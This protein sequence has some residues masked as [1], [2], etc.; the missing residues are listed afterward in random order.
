MDK[1]TT[2]CEEVRHL[3]AWYPTSTLSEEEERRVREHVEACESCSELLRFA[4]DTQEK[5]ETTSS[6]HPEP[7][8]LVRFAEEPA[9]LT[10][11]ERSA[12]EGHVALCEEC[13]QEIAI[14]EAVDA[15]DPTAETAPLPSP[16]ARGPGL[17]GR[18]CRLWD[19]LTTTLLR[20][21]PAALY[22]ATATAAV[23]LLLLQPGGE[24]GRRP[25]PGEI[26]PLRGTT[27]GS[28][29]LL[30]DGSDRVRGVGDEGPVPTM[31]AGKAQFLLLEF[32][33][34]AVPPGADDSYS[35]EL[36]ED[37]TGQTT[38]KRDVKGKTFAD[39]YTLY[40]VLEPGTLKSGRYM[41][42]VSSAAGEVIFR[43][44]LDVR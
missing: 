34:L 8:L 5:L 39:N 14:L 42:R 32:T 7:E 37:Q 29:V 25:W 11:Q 33:N 40:L 4:T 15:E 22:L 6:A 12:I 24:L 21:V 41:I 20:P 17:G 16:V 38:W 28:V 2:G 1:G 18:L 30:P 9:A 44:A 27:V 31:E 26:D 23:L 19:T 36:V 3:I 10:T 13:A 35:V 43:S